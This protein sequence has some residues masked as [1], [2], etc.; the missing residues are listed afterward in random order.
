M[1][2]F[3]AIIFLGFLLLS[4]GLGVARMLDPAEPSRQF[5]L[6]LRVL[7]L[8]LGGCVGLFAWLAWQMQ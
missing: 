7:L 8:A 3:L 1:T 5:R 2:G 6:V 4:C